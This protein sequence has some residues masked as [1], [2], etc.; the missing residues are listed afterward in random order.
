MY[1][2]PSESI[3][4]LVINVEKNKRSFIFCFRFIN[5]VQFTK[6]IVFKY[7][8]T[9]L[10]FTML[11]KGTILTVYIVLHHNSNC[12]NWCALIKGFKI[13]TWHLL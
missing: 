6:V 12:N 9:N 4:F 8:V 1:S 3:L 7:Y 13:M 5:C 11:S 2:V 10:K